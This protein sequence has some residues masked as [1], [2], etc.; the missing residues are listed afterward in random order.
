MRASGLAAR[1]VW[2]TTAR[3]ADVGHSA[4]ACGLR[5]NT[6]CR[7]R[8]SQIASCCADGRDTVIALALCL[9]KEPLIAPS[10]CSETPHLVSGLFCPPVH[11][12]LDFC[13]SRVERLH[14]RAMVPSPLVAST[15]TRCRRHLTSRRLSSGYNS[16]SLHKGFM[17]H[18]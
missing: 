16:A 15:S 12:P 6:G 18:L 3:S 13:T 11:Y 4:L 14:H 10:P 2:L 17:T 8:L 5:L 9:S 1:A 7:Q